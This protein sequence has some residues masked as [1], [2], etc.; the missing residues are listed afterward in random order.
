MGE[1]VTTG[2]STT[3]TR[4]E[5]IG[6]VLEVAGEVVIVLAVV[7]IFLAVTTFF[8]IATYGTFAGNNDPNHFRIPMGTLMVG[9]FLLTCGGGVKFVGIVLRPI[10]DEEDDNG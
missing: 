4:T 1:A 6:A 9:A 7:A 2:T 5:R 3:P 8:A 10:D